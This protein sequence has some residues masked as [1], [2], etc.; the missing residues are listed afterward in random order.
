ML[1]H[2]E[3]MDLIEYNDKHGFSKPRR[4]ASM[5][6]MRRWLLGIDDAPVETD[7]PLFK[8]EELRCT[9]TG[10]VLSEL[11]GKSVFDLD[12]EREK[13]LAAQRGGLTKDQ[14]S[15]IVRRKL[16]LS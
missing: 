11:K 14:L 8:E 16:G 10:Q 3:R 6:W 15:T 2:A 13:E 9:K 7:F 5:R 1:G 4:E 12:I